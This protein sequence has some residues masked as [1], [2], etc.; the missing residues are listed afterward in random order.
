MGE[1]KVRIVA[2]ADT[3]RVEY[4]CFVYRWLPHCNFKMASKQAPHTFNSV[5]KV[6][7]SIR[8][9]KVCLLGNQ[10]S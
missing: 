7:Q 9:E 5:Y 10:E 8:E 2:I 4:N 1:N 6:I 3:S